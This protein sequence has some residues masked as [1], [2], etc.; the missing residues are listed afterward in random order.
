[1]QYPHIP[2]SQIRFQGNPSRSM[3]LSCRF[4]CVVPDVAEDVIADIG[5]HDGGLVMWCHVACV[6]DMVVG[7]VALVG[8]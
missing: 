5:E 8:G 2:S 1:M 3:V 6:E 7:E 4:V